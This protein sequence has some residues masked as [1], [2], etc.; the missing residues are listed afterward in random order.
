MS[1][2]NENTEKFLM[3]LGVDI[4]DPLTSQLEFF[5]EGIVN[6]TDINERITLELLSGDADA[7]SSL[8]DSV[9]RFYHFSGLRARFNPHRCYRLVLIILPKDYIT[10][11]QDFN[12]EFLKLCYEKGD[13]IRR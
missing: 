2:N 9:A 12:Q 3:N 5:C 10:V 4:I 11:D 7:G 13:C 6:V 8:R 1:K